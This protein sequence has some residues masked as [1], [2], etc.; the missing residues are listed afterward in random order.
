MTLLLTCGTTRAEDP[1]ES[2]LTVGRLFGA[3]E[4]DTESLPARRWSKR[5]ATYF[6][7]AWMLKKNGMSI[8]DVTVVNLSPQA[9]ANAMIAGTAGIHRLNEL[10]AVG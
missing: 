1:P 9:A 4:F 2:V 7:L 5:S 6:T 10:H 3:K 8:K